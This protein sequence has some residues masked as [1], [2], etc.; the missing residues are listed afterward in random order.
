MWRAGGP[1]GHVAPAAHTG[2]GS[3]QLAGRDRGQVGS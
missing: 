2:R 3:N 1:T